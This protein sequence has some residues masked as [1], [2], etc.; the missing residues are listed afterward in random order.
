MSL[1]DVLA[2][3][4]AL[5]GIIGAT[6]G[7]GSFVRDRA[8]I[9]VVVHSSSI[10]IKDVGE[11][12]VIIY[13]V[14]AGRQP[15][16]VLS[17]GLWD[18]TRATVWR[19]RVA[20]FRRWTPIRL[21]AG[22]RRWNTVPIHTALSPEDE[23]IVLQPGELRRFFLKAVNPSVITDHRKTDRTAIVTDYRGLQY[24]GTVPIGT[25]SS[26]VW[27]PVATLPRLMESLGDGDGTVSQHWAGSLLDG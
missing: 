9:V 26:L 7:V 25:V 4:G 23:P 13:V 6:L 22:H 2:I 10:T 27:V 19:A 16:A 14:N 15:I 18:F 3:V 24:F 11:H 8:R 17:V 12:F 5:A 20:A 21:I 1:T